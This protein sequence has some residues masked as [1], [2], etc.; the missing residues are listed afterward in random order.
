MKIGVLPPDVNQSGVKFTV[1]G[2]AIRFGLAGI[3]GVGVKTA[4]AIIANRAEKN[5][6][7]NLMDFCTRIDGQFINRRV[8]EALVKCG[9]FDFTSD[10]LA[11]LFAQIE[12]SLKIAQRE[13]SDAVKNQIGLFGASA[14]KLPPPP[15]REAIVEWSAKEKLKLEKETLGFYITAH[16]L[17][18][19]ERELARV[20]KVTTDDLAGAPDGSMV[21]LAGVVQAVKLKN[22]KSGK[23]YATFALEDR[24]GAVEVIAWPESYQKYESI[25]SGDEPVMV[26]GKLDVDEERAQIIL[27]E[28]KTLDAALLAS[29]REVRIRAPKSRLVNGGL[30]QLRDTISKFPGRSMTYLHLDVDGGREAVLLLS[31]RFRVTPTEAFVA[32]IEQVL[33]PGSVELR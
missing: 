15:R 17:D 21:Q 20:S 5:A 28:L 22:N 25:I 32:A 11:V 6:Y 3:R 12:D 13:Q 31:D 26:R 14:A 18:A 19:Y 10:S 33:S 7:E 23:R 27:D 24:S 4:E 16:P 9:A 1:A 30:D 2:E 29:I 8:L